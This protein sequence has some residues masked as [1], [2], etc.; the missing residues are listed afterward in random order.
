[1]LVNRL[2][3][4]LS[5]SSVI[6]AGVVTL[7]SA[8]ALANG[9]QSSAKDMNFATL[10]PC[11][12]ASRKAHVVL[13]E[14]RQNASSTSSRSTCVQ[15]GTLPLT[16]TAPIACSSGKHAEKQHP[17]APY[18]ILFFFSGF[19]VRQGNNT[20]GRLLGCTGI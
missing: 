13:E 1:M 9:V 4:I 18:P 8:R 20:V 10:G 5:F 6:V 15:C 3:R 11:K 17:V 7:I 12:T 14:L 2:P 19:K 16:I